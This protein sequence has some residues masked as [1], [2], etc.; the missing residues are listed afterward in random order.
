M[1]SRISR[2]DRLIQFLTSSL[3]VLFYAFLFSCFN[4][5]LISIL[6]KFVTLSI[7]FHAIQKIWNVFCIIFCYNLITSLMVF[8]LGLYRR[9]IIFMDKIFQFIS[10]NES[11]F[12]TLES[13][14]NSNGTHP[15]RDFEG[16]DDCPTGSM[17]GKASKSEN[18][19]PKI[20][21]EN[22][23]D[24]TYLQMSIECFTPG[25][26]EHWNMLQPYGLRGGERIPLTSIGKI[27]WISGAIVRF[28]F[29]LPLRI[30]LFLSSFHYLVV[31]LIAIYWVPVLLKAGYMSGFSIFSNTSGG[32]S[33][34]HDGH[35]APESE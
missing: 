15:E 14:E 1:R 21:E 6:S 22:H 19:R 9:Y 32:Y 3:F 4:H 31:N 16:S 7:I 34:V 29:L 11:I 26:P 5:I 30:S 12:L 33:R 10:R 17:S 2:I 23:I 28:G 24:P 20:T 18:S 25:E 35:L 27:V 13:E 8:D